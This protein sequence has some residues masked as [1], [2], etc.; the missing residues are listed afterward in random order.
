MLSER[1]RARRGSPTI[2][3]I[4]PAGSDVREASG[5]IST[6]EQSEAASDAGSVVSLESDQARAA[7]GVINCGVAPPPPPTPGDWQRDSYGLW[8]LMS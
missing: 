8:R 5:G 1:E 4:M 7:N 3:P 2:L 6:P